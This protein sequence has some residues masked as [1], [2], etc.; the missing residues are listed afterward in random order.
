MGVI[1]ADIYN[2]RNDIKPITAFK[3]KNR[4]GGTL[5][6]FNGHLGQMDWSCLAAGKS[7]DV[8]K[9]SV[10]PVEAEGSYSQH[11]C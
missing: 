8:Q 11:C 2:N 10:T 3:K 1:S 9:I 5:L 4:D 7:T 6:F